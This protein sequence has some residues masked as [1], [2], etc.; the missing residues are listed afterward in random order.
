MFVMRFS[1]VPFLLYIHFNI[2]LKITE[3]QFKKYLQNCLCALLPVS[4]TY[5]CK[6]RVSSIYARACVCMCTCAPACILKE[7]KQKLKII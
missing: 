4:K 7:K 1:V 2:D 6:N 3:N 5:I